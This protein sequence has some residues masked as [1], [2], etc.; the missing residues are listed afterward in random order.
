MVN[1]VVISSNGVISDVL[2]P[3][4]TND[5]LEWSRKKYKNSEIQFQGKIQDPLRDSVWLSIFA[6]T[7]GL[8]ENINQHILPSPLDEE[9]YYGQILVFAT[10]SEEQDEYEQSITSYITIKSDHYELLYQE[11]TFDGEDEE[12]ILEEDEDEEEEEEEEVHTR[13]VFESRPV[14]THSKNVFIE[15]PIRDKVIENYNELMKDGELASQVEESILH[16]ITDQATK[17]N[18]EIDWTNKVFFN[19]YRSKCISI[20]ENLRGDQSYVKNQENWLNRLKNGEITPRNFAELTNV[21][22]CPARWKASIERII[23]SQKR[24]YS[25]NES[26]AIFMW[27]SSCKKKT[28]CDYYQMQTRSADEPMTT[29]VNCLECDRRWKF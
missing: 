4:K 26:A 27:C 24:L 19:M 7:T 29:F 25:K 1:C 2:V 9:T 6:A 5:V 14:L 18:I 23:E 16:V 3:A 11:W 8:E 15:T 17:E 10:K 20:Y 22:L 12:E 21:E 28:K 13:E